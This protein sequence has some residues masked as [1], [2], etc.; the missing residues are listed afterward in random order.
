MVEPERIE[1]SFQHTPVKGFCDG[2]TYLAPGLSHSLVL[3]L[4]EKNI[5]FCKRLKTEFTPSDRNRTYRES[6]TLCPGT[7][8]LQG[9][10]LNL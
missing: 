9:E 10:D 1:L 8:W 6:F 7:Q 2:Q 3:P 5:L 4:A